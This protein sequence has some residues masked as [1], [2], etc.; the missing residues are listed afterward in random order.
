MDEKNKG[1]DQLLESLKTE[2][3]SEITS[4]PGPECPD[5][6]K[7]AAYLDGKLEGEDGEAIEIHIAECDHCMFS[8]EV[9]GSTRLT[10]DSSLP[11]LSP[12][13]RERVRS[14]ITAKIEAPKVDRLLEWLKSTLFD[15]F[16][17]FA[18]GPAFRPALA[19]AAVAL[20]A[21]IGARH[22]L[23]PRT[24]G[25]VGLLLAAAP[26][27]LERAGEA[28]VPEA[29]AARLT[30]GRA[31]DPASFLRLELRTT[32]RDRHITALF[33]DASGLVIDSFA[34]P[35]TGERHTLSIPTA[36][37]AGPAVLVTA[38]EGFTLFEA[39]ADRLLGD[40]FGEVLSICLVSEKELRE[41]DR[42]TLQATLSSDWKEDLEGTESR[43]RKWARGKVE[44]YAIGSF[45][46]RPAVTP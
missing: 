3:P 9:L 20:V 4:E 26:V 41:P 24:P 11:T 44:T 6:E 33:I 36:R 13:V 21:V 29:T 10:E 37:S 43:L 14:L 45:T 34:S 19:T 28:G 35:P 2:P 1:F 15:P 16:F 7:L 46:Y 23:A 39:K 30:P 31:L 27:S 42:Q 22:L 38:S 25:R 32:A 5:D 18:R 8:L 17:D 12:D 40:R